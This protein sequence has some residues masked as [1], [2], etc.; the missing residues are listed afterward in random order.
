ME[1]EIGIFCAVPGTAI[2]KHH[3]L[4]R[5]KQEK[6]VASQLE[7]QKSETGV[8]AECAPS[9]KSLLFS[10]SWCLPSWGAPCLLGA[11]PSPLG[12]VGVFVFSLG[13]FQPAR[14]DHGSDSSM[15]SFDLR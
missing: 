13:L 2:T 15:T 9:E 3:K 10:P 5:L 11:F 4:G 12:S 7:G 6:C 1:E 8:S 14:L